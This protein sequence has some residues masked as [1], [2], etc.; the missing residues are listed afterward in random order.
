MYDAPWFFST[1]P[2][3]PFF[4]A[5]VDADVV[6]YAL[7]EASLSE[8]LACVAK[9]CPDSYPFALALRTAMLLYADG[10]PFNTTSG[11]TVVPPVGTVVN[12]GYKSVVKRDTVGPLTRE[13]EQVPI[14][15]ASED[16]ATVS[17]S[18]PDYAKRLASLLAACK[19]PTP[20]K[21]RGG[22]LALL[23]PPATGCSGCSGSGI[24]DKTDDMQ[25]LYW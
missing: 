15:Q 2:G 11:T 16:P 8:G 1:R 7:K 10:E 21:F 18:T 25:S 19:P 6:E 24:A 22:S 17:D 3:K 14:D 5:G 13:Y 12:T 20:P 9:W 4:D 23:S